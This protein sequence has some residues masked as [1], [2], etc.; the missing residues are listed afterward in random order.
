MV[1]MNLR[2]GQQW[3][4][5]RGEGTCGDSGGRRGYDFFGCR[6]SFTRKTLGPQSYIKF[7]IMGY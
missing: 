2:T 3:K 7:L 5:R 1:L 6:L 4:H